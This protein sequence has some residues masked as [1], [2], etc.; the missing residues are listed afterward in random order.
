[1][2]TMTRS[3]ITLALC[4]VIA[5]GGLSLVNKLTKSRVE[6]SQH[7]WLLK[8][9]LEI[10]PPGPYDNDPLQSLAWIEAS[11]LGSPDALPVYT[12]YQQSKPYAAVLSVI[13]PDGYNG[14]IELLMGVQYNG[15]IVGVRVT[16]HRETPGLGDD[17]ESR[18]SDWINSFANE[19]LS[20]P[21]IWNVKK[22]GGKFD[23]FTGAT[24]TPKA[25]ISAVHR[26]LQWFV[27]NRDAVFSP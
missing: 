24:I 5:V 18:R 14:A 15:E 3:G 7:E 17:I 22:H 12:V 11:E 23:S 21:S 16:A 19:S 27:S 6:Q 8:S 26:A 9:L 4:V 20:A 1:M 10:L 25:V 2:N 13:A